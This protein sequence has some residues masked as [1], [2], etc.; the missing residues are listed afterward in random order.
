MRPLKCEEKRSWVLG[1]FVATA[2]SLMSGC[3]TLTKES[4]AVRLQRYRPAV[5]DRSVHLWD[6]S[7]VATAVP[8]DLTSPT[9]AQ[10]AIPSVTPTEKQYTDRL[11]C[12]G[13][14]IRVSLRGIPKPENIEEV[15]DDIGEIT[16]PLIGP[17]KVEG[18]RTSDVESLLQQKYVQGGYYNTIDVIVMS[19]E[20]AY[21]V[22]GEVKREGR[23]PL[24]GEMTLL[25]AITSAGGY[26]D[27][28]NSR[29]VEIIRGKEV[30]HFD[31]KRI[32][33]LKDADPQV[34][35]DDVIVV[36]SKML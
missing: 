19:Q 20:R 26:T 22:R 30:L 3:A 25:Q 16:L 1:L 14:S 32:E 13:D 8:V 4:E 33:E 36:R 27:Y 31:L 21:Y 29:K 10:P 34:Q 15:V 6:T 5:H 2:L 28:A 7:A 24:L 9:T 18:K 23:C 17:V 35:P 12:R 11:L